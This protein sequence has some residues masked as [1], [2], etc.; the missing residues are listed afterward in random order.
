MIEENSVSKIILKITQ[1]G[2]HYIVYDDSGSV[3]PSFLTEYA[4]DIF[5]EQIDAASSSGYTEPADGLVS[6]D[7]GPVDL[8]FLMV[9][10]LDDTPLIYIFNIEQLKTDEQTAQLIQQPWLYSDDVNGMSHWFNHKLVALIEDKIPPFHHSNN[11]IT[12]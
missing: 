12:H 1:S 8:V 11:N 7:D 6:S 9:M 2:I 3:D 4:I 10:L 5:E